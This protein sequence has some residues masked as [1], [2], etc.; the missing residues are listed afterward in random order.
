MKCD[1]AQKFYFFKIKLC[2][3]SIHR[4]NSPAFLTALCATLKEIL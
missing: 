3:Q 2:W 1:Q 4:Y